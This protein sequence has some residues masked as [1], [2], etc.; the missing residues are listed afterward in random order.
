MTP[1]LTAARELAAELDKYPEGHWR[2]DK[3]L[4]EL[5]TTIRDLAAAL[6]AAQVVANGS[7]KLYKSG[8]HLAVCDAWEELMW[9]YTEY[10]YG[11]D[12]WVE[13]L[14]AAY[15]VAQDERMAF[16]LEKRPA[17]HPQPE[18]RIDE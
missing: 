13:K 5:S 10:G 3:R 14:D 18:G 2:S 12:Y 11:L 1:D 4:S 16:M 7:V 6:E 8:F 15:K 17:A 9:A